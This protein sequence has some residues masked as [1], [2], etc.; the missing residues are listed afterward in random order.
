MKSLYTRD[1]LV[2]KIKDID[3]K[4]DAAASADSYSIN[5]GMSS[6]SVKRQSLDALLKLK[7]HYEDKLEE[8]DALHGCS[9]ILYPMRSRSR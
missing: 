3:L 2:A 5:S 8:W 9:S 6:Q 7:K 4:I 1:E